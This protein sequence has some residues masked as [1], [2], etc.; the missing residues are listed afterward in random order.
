[1]AFHKTSSRASQRSHKE[2]QRDA[3]ERM[4]SIVRAPHNTALGRQGAPSPG[5]RADQK[6][7][8][9][10]FLDDTPATHRCGGVE[11]PVCGARHLRMISN[12]TAGFRKGIVWII[13][14]FSPKTSNGNIFLHKRSRKIRTQSRK[15]R[16]TVQQTHAHF[17]TRCLSDCETNKKG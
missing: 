9:E 6:C 16:P 2:D 4:S 5:E 12:T 3:K 8:S 1:M 15:T 17:P 10:R 14:E 11:R 7:E 13:V